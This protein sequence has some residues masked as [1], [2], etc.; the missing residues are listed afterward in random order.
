MSVNISLTRI[1]GY[2]RQFAESCLLFFGEFD[3][4]RGPR[5]YLSLGYRVSLCPIYTLHLRSPT[6]R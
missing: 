4:R 5:R 3:E 2:T 6:V 1:N